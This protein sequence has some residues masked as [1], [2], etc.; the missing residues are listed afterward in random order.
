MNDTV[1]VGKQVRVAA[2]SFSA[3]I[4]HAQGLSG[5]LKVREVS[6]FK[7]LARQRRL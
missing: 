7:H 6:R 5:D 4:S 1:D 2:V 3:L